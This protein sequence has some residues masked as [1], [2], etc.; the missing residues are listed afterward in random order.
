[1]RSGCVIVLGSHVHRC[2]FFVLARALGIRIS[3]TA[4]PPAA[5]QRTR[6][7]PAQGRVL[8]DHPRDVRE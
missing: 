1:M 7:P 5:R 6:R 2:V 8:A 4:S 3:R